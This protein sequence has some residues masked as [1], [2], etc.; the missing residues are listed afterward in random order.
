MCFPGPARRED[1]ARGAILQSPGSQTEAIA[2]V[3]REGETADA[4]QG[5]DEPTPIHRARQ[6]VLNA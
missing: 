4:K 2:D 1:R 5:R 3:V 6:C